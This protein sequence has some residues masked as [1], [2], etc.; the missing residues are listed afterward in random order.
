MF[1]GDQLK[2]ITCNDGSSEFTLGVALTKIVGVVLNCI[3][4]N[5]VEWLLRN[6]AD[7]DDCALLQLSP[8]STICTNN[9]RSRKQQM[10]GASSF[11]DLLVTGGVTG[12][13]GAND[14]Y[15]FLGHVTNSLT[16]TAQEP[17]EILVRNTPVQFK[18]F[19]RKLQNFN[20]NSSSRKWRFV[21]SEFHNK[22]FHSADPFSFT[23]YQNPIFAAVSL[24]LSCLV[25]KTYADEDHDSV[26]EKVWKLDWKSRTNI[27]NKRPTIIALFNAIHKKKATNTNVTKMEAHLVK[28]IYKLKTSTLNP[29]T[30]ILSVVEFLKL[31][32]IALYA[33]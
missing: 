25:N 17:H 6:C 2:V 26:M 31:Y 9:Q 20:N 32:N 23:N 5:D 14:V 10:D 4:S 30:S 19:S 27:A 16:Q 8:R 22:G 18:A 29:K 33:K 15:P 13:H 28:V 7:I 11:F 3:V 21:S 12:V 24:L 1:L